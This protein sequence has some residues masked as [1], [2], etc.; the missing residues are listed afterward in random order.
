MHSNGSENATT[1]SSL[2]PPTESRIRPLCN[3]DPMPC[4]NLV[5]PNS[6]WFSLRDLNPCHLSTCATSGSKMRGGGGGGG[7]HRPI[8]VHLSCY[9]DLSFPRQFCVCFDALVCIGLYQFMLLHVSFVSVFLLQPPSNVLLIM[10][11]L[12]KKKNF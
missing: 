12:K 11:F 3:L 2:L 10:Y 8:H 7:P 4:R 1:R 9:F 6:S 5:R